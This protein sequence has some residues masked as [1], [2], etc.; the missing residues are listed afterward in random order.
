MRLSL[1]LALRNPSPARSR[2]ESAQA[3][4][5]YG[6]HRGAHVTLFRF[7]FGAGDHA[8]FLRREATF[9]STFPRVWRKFKKVQQEFGM[10]WREKTCVGVANQQPSPQE[11]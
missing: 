9:V 11:R 10:F 6:R 5:N 3:G 8:Q 7:F 4:W 2:Y 1:A